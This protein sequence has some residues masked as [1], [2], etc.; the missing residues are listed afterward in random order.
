MADPASTTGNTALGMSAKGLATLTQ[1]EHLVPSYYNDPADC[2]FMDSHAQTFFLSQAALR[3]DRNLISR[4][5]MHSG[6]VT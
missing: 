3:L 1:H 5:S 4:L 2:L 6:D